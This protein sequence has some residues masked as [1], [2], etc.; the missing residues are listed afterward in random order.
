MLLNDTIKKF[1][2]VAARLLPEGILE[3]KNSHSRF[4]ENGY[5]TLVAAAGFEPTTFGLWEI[6]LI[7][8]RISNRIWLN[9]FMAILRHFSFLNIHQLTCCE[10][11]IRGQKHF[12]YFCC[13][14]TNITHSLW[15]LVVVQSI[16]NSPLSLTSLQCTFLLLWYTT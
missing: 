14:P 13:S 12:K 2:C 10:D 4:L 5:I 16:F 3:Q 15:P 7:I 9:E 8:L 1:F 11:V 6:Y